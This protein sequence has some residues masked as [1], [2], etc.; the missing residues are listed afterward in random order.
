MP[1]MIDVFLALVYNDLAHAHCCLHTD[2]YLWGVANLDRPPFQ[3]A[4]SALRHVCRALAVLPSVAQ[5]NM[6][7]QVSTYE[8]L[9]PES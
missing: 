4:G 3:I 7:F 9:A 6:A 5:Q 2:L 1:Y 8:H